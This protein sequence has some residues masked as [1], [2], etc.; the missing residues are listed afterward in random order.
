MEEI[1]PHEEVTLTETGKDVSDYLDI[2]DFLLIFMMGNSIYSTYSEPFYNNLDMNLEPLTSLYIETIEIIKINYRNLHKIVRINY[3][4]FSIIIIFLITYFC[5]HESKKKKQNQKTRDVIEYNRKLCKQL[6][7]ERN[8]IALEL[9][10]GAAQKL[11]A[12]SR[13][14]QQENSA[15]NRYLMNSYCNDAISNIRSISHFLR[16]PDFN[17]FALKQQLIIFFGDFRQYSDIKLQTRFLGID[18]LR[19]DDETNLHIY[20][21]IQELLTN[22]YKHSQADTITLYIIYSSPLLRI[23]YKDNG[24]GKNEVH[25]FSGMGSGSL[26]YRTNYLRGTINESNRD[27]Y[28]VTISIPVEK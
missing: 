10:D 23:C 1:E 13:Y 6:E 20:R 16:S 17:S 9:H 11:A 14:L 22:G 4:T 18:Y 7:Y 8:F 21:I 12:L 28:S 26:E 5:I 19:M 15:F 27:G 2:P 3:F 24:R 25:D